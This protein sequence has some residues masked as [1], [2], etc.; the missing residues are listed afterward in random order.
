VLDALAL[1]L[2]LA[3]AGGVTTMLVM[4]RLRRALAR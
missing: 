4:G 3:L 1:G 2:A